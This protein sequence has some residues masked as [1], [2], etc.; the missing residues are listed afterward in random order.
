MSTV[1]ELHVV[2]WNIGLRDAPMRTLRGSGYDV[3]LLQETRLPEDTWEREHYDRGTAVLGL[4]ARVKLLKLRSIPQGRRP[5]RDEVAV[6]APGTIAAAHI[7]PETGEPFIA[8]SLYARWERPHPLTPSSWGVGYSDAMAH[9]AISDLSAFIGH[10]DPTKHRLLVAGDF[11]LIHGATDTNPLALPER[12]RSVFERLDALGLKFMGPQHPNGRSA[13]P[14]P[15]GLAPNTRNVPTYYTSH[16]KPRDSSE[17][18]GLCVR[19]AGI[20][21]KGPDA[22]AQ[23][24]PRVGT[25]RPLPDCHRRRR[26]SRDSGLEGVA[27][28]RGTKNPIRS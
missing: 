23:Y 13:D 11:N 24:T 5:G 1:T 9:R 22:C 10:E 8:V 19:V 21:P 18:A 26:V 7:I 3:A 16:Q 2:S 17:P 6:S 15:Q 20:S 27:G 12:D 14:T 4:S 28:C 25:E